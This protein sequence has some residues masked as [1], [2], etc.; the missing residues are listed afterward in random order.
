MN[1]INRFFVS[2]LA[3]FLLIVAPGCGRKQ[4]PFPPKEALKTF[5][6]DPAWRIDLFASEPM[7]ASPVAMD[8]DEDGRIY[9][10]QN[11]GY[12]L[13]AEH[14]VGK[15]WLLEDTDGDGKP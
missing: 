12:P 8:I 2:P 14:A 15:V 9:V 3:A 5:Q 7:F 1:R 6:I 10:V 4:P 13:D 11:S